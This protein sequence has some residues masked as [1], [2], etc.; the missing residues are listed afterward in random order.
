MPKVSKKG[1]SPF[2]LANVLQG[3]LVNATNNKLFSYNAGEK[4]MQCG[5][6]FKS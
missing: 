2:S 3:Y 4:P 5:W 6:A 1:I